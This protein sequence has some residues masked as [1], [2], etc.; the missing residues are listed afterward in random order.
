MH[1]RKSLEQVRMGCEALVKE[2]ERVHGW[3]EVSVDVSDQ[4]SKAIKDAFLRI[5]GVMIRLNHKRDL[6]QIGPGFTNADDTDPVGRP[7][8]GLPVTGLARAFIPD[9]T[10]LSE[11]VPRNDPRIIPA[12]EV[13]TID[14][15]DA[16]ES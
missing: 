2:L 16:E 3:A 6:A 14:L 4:D 11:D 12:H 10:P 7:S 13:R 1:S 5:R 15:T 8:L 9:T